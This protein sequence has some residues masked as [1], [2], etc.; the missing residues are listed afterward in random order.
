MNTAH[1]EMFYQDCEASMA[2]FQTN[3]EMPQPAQSERN[4]DDV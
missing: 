3:R 1:D 2:L 4:K